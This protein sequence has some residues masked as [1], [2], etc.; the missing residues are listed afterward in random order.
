MNLA[1][2]RGPC[3]VSGYIGLLHLEPICQPPPFFAQPHLSHSLRTLCPPP[4]PP[5]I[6]L[7]S[8]ITLQIAQLVLAFVLAGAFIL[9]MVL[10][11]VKDAWTETRRIAELLA[12]VG[13]G[14]E[15]RV[16][17]H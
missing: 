1:L 11:F 16:R 5:H 3:P 10:P 14:K 6:L 7:R 4:P 15:G 8:G 13:A 9:L 12:Q 17:H 2:S